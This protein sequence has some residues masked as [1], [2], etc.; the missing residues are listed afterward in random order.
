MRLKTTYF[1]K[2]II[3]DVCIL[4][5]EFIDLPPITPVPKFKKVNKTRAGNISLRFPIRERQRER[6]RE[7]ERERTI[8]FERDD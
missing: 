6:E 5:G 2:I 4:Y 8:P 3:F 1:S 7:R